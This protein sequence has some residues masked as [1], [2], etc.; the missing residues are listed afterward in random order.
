[1]PESF[2]WKTQRFKVIRKPGK[3]TITLKL[4]CMKKIS[5][6]F[7]DEKYQGILIVLIIFVLAA[8]VTASMLF[9]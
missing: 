9:L 6:L 3:S 2:P 5:S 1:M 8:L 4:L 7:Y